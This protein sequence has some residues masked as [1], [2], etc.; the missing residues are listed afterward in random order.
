MREVRE[1]CFLSFSKEYSP[2]FFRL[3]LC[4]RGGA[5]KG[6]GF[7]KGTT[8]WNFPGCGDIERYVAPIGYQYIYTCCQ[9]I[10]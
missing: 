6:H 8:R 4:Y 10:K 9:G 3:F 2:R 7:S 1:R 5:G